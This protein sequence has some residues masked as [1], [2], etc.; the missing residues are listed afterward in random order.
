[1][2]ELKFDQLECQNN[3]VMD[4]LQ[5]VNIEKEQSDKLN[6]SL[7]LMMSAQKRI[8]MQPNHNCS[9]MI[10]PQNKKVLEEDG[11]QCFDLEMVQEDLRMSIGANSAQES[12]MSLIQQMEKNKKDIDTIRNQKDKIEKSKAE[13]HLE[14][15][16]EMRE[17]IQ[18]LREESMIK[19]ELLQKYENQHQQ[20]EEE[21][22]FYK[23]QNGCLL[24][25][26]DEYEGLI[27]NTSCN[28][29]Q[30]G[31]ENQSLL[32]SE[33]LHLNKQID[34]QKQDLMQ[35]DLELKKIE[36]IK[37]DLDYKLRA[38]HYNIEILKSQ[39][40]NLNMEMSLLRKQNERQR[41]LI[42]M[43]RSKNSTIM[44]DLEFYK[45]QTQAHNSAK[46]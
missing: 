44:G 10:S 3:M 21:V 40:E 28:I 14:S 13:Q 39:N 26:L 8:S 5:L 17:T 20:Y 30:H 36:S 12:D 2:F 4:N 16:L 25:R 45:G 35:N 7:Q 38:S 29:R 43:Q 41:K 24:T 37:A 19:N 1:M 22:A 15:A 42:G 34:G 6:E 18:L 11:I 27:N 46:K 23:K 33:N 31:E 32:R 9:A